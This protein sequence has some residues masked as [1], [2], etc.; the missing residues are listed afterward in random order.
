MALE[1]ARRPLGAI[2]G[3]YR[4]EGDGG[5]GLAERRRAPT[6]REK[7]AL[8]DRA[9]HRCEYCERMFGTVVEREGRRSLLV[10]EYDHLI[11][12][13]YLMSN[14]P[15]NWIVACQLCNRYKS[16]QVF[17][18]FDEVRLYLLEVQEE[19]GWVTIWRASVPKYLDADQWARD[20]AEWLTH[21]ASFRIRGSNYDG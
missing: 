4:V 21:Q 3:A 1:R 17:D 16:D 10:P 14:P 11:P 2:L 18:S 13:A 20:F 15:T 12:Y 5:G 7:K 6:G 19:R 8:L 9:G